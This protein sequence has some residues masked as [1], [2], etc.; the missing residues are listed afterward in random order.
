MRCLTM[1]EP[2]TTGDER[3]YAEALVTK[4]GT[5]LDAPLYDLSAVDVCRP[6][7]PHLPLPFAAHYFHAVSAE[8]SRIN[9]AWPVDAYFSGNGGDN[10]F[11]SLRS[12]APLARSEERR[13][14]KEWVGT[15]GSGWRPFH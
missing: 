2:G 12:A 5:R 1:V 8:H 3:R 7:L 6:V 11:C 15:C 13:V 9:A 10:V 4:L 14:G